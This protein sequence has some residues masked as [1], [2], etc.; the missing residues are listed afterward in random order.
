MHEKKII[1]YLTE[2]KVRKYDFQRLDINEFESFL[3][4][5]TEVHELID[6]IHPGF[7][8]MFTNQYQD[9][10]IK[11]FSSLKDWKE[12]MHILKKDFGKNILI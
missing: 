1:V 4:Y 5:K 2:F 7:S 9:I 11:N 12:R 6:Y 3:G 10:R 8:S